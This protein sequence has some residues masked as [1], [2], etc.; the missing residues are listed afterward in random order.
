MDK[1]EP[2]KRRRE[3][4]VYLVHYFD[5]NI[6][7][8]F[9]K[10]H[11]E[12]GPRF[13]VYLLAEHGTRVAPD[14][15]DRYSVEFFQFSKIKKMARKV[16]GERIL[17]GNCHL[18]TIDFFHRHPSYERY[19]FIEFDVHY[20]G[21]WSRF[22]RQFDDDGSDLLAATVHSLAQERTWVWADS[23]SAPKRRLEEDKRLI[24]FLPAHRLSSR[25]IQEIE[26]RVGMGW[27]G[28]FEMLIPTAILDAGL[29]VSDIGGTGPWTPRRRKNR[30]YISV[31]V[32][33][34]N[35]L[36]TFRFRPPVQILAI[37]DFLYH[38]IKADL[39]PWERF[40]AFLMSLSDVVKHP[41]A[42]VRFYKAYIS[43]LLRSS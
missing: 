33:G 7:K 31:R 1:G 32:Y 35:T 38:P 21:D 9:D 25:A 30:N 17:P 42:S 39:G 34:V 6:R 4:I 8:R 13:D 24:A 28:H 18:R 16:I 40:K 43:A 14:F 12:T 2:S 11:K 10:L 26:Q 20:S 5:D 15:M 29:S 23:F 3:C 36:Q 19:W 27:V 37:K 41:I 22:F